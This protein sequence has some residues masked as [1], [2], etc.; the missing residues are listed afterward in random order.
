MHYRF[1][2]GS[3]LARECTGSARLINAMLRNLP[4]GATF[5]AIM[6]APNGDGEQDERP[7]PA[8]ELVE[9]LERKSWTEDRRLMAQ[10]INS[11][12]MLVRFAP[13]WEEG[14]A[15]EFPVV[16]PAE[17]REGGHDTAASE[18][19]TGTNAKSVMDVLKLFS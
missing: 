15:P 4:E 8:P 17:W 1:D 2:L 10:L 6:S 13:K 9:L 7:E 11:V 16:G 5:T 18:T 12:N 3:F 14:K 19:P